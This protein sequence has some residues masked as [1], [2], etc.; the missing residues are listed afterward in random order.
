MNNSDE[1]FIKMIVIII[2]VR[3]VEPDRAKRF[4]YINELVQSVVS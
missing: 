4:L 2:L 3:N 1:E